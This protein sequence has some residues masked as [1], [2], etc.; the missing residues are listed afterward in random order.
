[1]DM[2]EAVTKLCVVNDPAK[3]AAKAVGD[4]NSSVRTF[5]AFHATLLTLE[6]LRC[7][8]SN[9]KCGSFT[10]NHLLA[11]IN[12]LIEMEDREYIP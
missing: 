10:K 7:L 2:K 11:V 4:R 6:E 1:M 8:S 5:K 9:I 12:I 3:R